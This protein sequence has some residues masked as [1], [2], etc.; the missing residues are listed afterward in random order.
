VYLCYLDD[1]IGRPPHGDATS[2]PSVL[3]AIYWHVVSLHIS[4]HKIWNHA[5]HILQ[6][7]CRCEQ[8]RMMILQHRLKATAISA[9]CAIGWPPSPVMVDRWSTVVYS[10]L[11]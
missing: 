5:Q 8:C 2:L 11:R 7:C 1:A 6:C 9:L 10:V 4:C 3:L